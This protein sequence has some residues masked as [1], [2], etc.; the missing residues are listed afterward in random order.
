MLTGRRLRQ[1]NENGQIRFS[2]RM[3][4]NK[5]LR[6]VTFQGQVAGTRMSL[7][8][9]EKIGINPRKTVLECGHGLPAD[10]TTVKIGRFVVCPECR[11]VSE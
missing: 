8:E 11:A 3:K 9:L 7:F 5:F 4:T 10:A 2:S 6:R 1:P